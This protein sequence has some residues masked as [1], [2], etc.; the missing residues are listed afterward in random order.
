MKAND[1]SRYVDNVDE[2]PDLHDYEFIAGIVGGGMPDKTGMK[3]LRYSKSPPM[4]N[5][6]FAR[7]GIN[8]LYIALLPKQSMLPDLYEYLKR[9]KR[10]MGFNVTNPYKKDVCEIISRDSG[11]LSQEARDLGVINTVYRTGTTFAG[12]TTDSR[13]AQLSFEGAGK[14]NN[15]LINGA[16]DTTL[17]VLHGIIPLVQ[18]HIYLLNRTA[19]K[20]HALARL[21]NTRIDEN[22]IIPLGKKDAILNPEEQMSLL[23]QHGSSVDAIINTTDAPGETFLS[24]D[25]A[26]QLKP[27][28]L[29]DVKYGEKTKGLERLAADAGH[30][31]YPFGKYMLIGQATY[32]FV[33]LFS[34]KYGNDSVPKLYKLM[35][36]N[37]GD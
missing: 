30:T 6:V 9:D 13:G 3:T 33:H 20:A 32:S 28:T 19:A 5:G 21:F 2:I 1:I 26:R 25:I 17:S 31:F 22:K 27:L 7:E 12:D 37:F 23:K 24:Y 18:E 8:A 35:E 4:W 11:V 16:G 34:E 36:Q 10:V 15:V 14:F 29:M